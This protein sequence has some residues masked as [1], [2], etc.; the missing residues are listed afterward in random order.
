MKSKQHC[1]VAVDRDGTEKIS[2]SILIRRRFK[3]SKILSIMWGWYTGTYSKNNRNKWCNGWSS[4]TN[5]FLPFDGVELPKGSI[6]KLI[7]R[8]LSW[9]D[10]PVELISEK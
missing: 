7:G 3:E 1:W 4:D 10:E 5:D 8:K 6:E 9:V 2:N